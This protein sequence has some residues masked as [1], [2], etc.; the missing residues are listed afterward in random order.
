MFSLLLVVLVL[1]QM[2]EE[3]GSLLDN[4]CLP[5]IILAGRVTTNEELEIML[6][7]GNPSIFTSD[8]SVVM[9]YLCSTISLAGLKAITAIW[10]LRGSTLYGVTV[11]CH[12]WEHL[13]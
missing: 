10:W 8:V 7:S 12:S 3:S 2:E 6:E 4:N 5:F 9:L 13:F 1:K 11:Y